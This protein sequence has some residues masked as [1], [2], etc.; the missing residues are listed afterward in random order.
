MI[1]N[2]EK[3]MSQVKLKPAALHSEAGTIIINKLFNMFNLMML[4]PSRVM[5]TTRAVAAKVEELITIVSNCI[6]P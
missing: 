5:G 3:S 4:Y 1:M 6:K 2:A